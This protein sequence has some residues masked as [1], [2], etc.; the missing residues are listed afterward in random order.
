[1]IQASFNIYPTLLA[2]QFTDTSTVETGKTIAS[3][4]WDFGDAGNAITQNPAHT[5]AAP[6]KYKVT[7]IVTDSDAGTLESVRY[8]MVD[9]KPI[10]P[11]TV[12]DLVKLKLPHNFPYQPAQLSA[13]ISTWQ[14]YVQP[15]VNAPGVAEGDAFTETA[16]PPVVNALIAY[17]AAYQIMIDY[18]SSAAVSAAG[19]GV[20]G[21][22]GVVKRIE[23]GPTNAEVFNPADWLKLLAQPNGLMDQVRKQLCMLSLRTRIDV[24]YCPKNPKPKFISLK[25]GRNDPSLLN[26][27]AIS[28]DDILLAY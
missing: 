26:L 9:T 21:E 8:I 23:T 16:Y 24:P 11:V 1:M 20:G 5:Y 27:W 22:E 28:P 15:L 19:S 14:I 10:L 6:G 13:I 17:L 12:E 18:V 2:V 7:L 4:A 25:A 3:W